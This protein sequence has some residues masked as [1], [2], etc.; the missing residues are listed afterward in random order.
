MSVEGGGHLA[1]GQALV[2]A[3]VDRRRGGAPRP[4][5]REHVRRVDGV[6]VVAVG[7]REVVRVALELRGVVLREDGEVRA[8]RVDG[9]RRRV[10]AWVRV[11]VRVRVRVGNPNPKPKP[12]PNLITRTLALDLTLTRYI[13]LRIK[14]MLEFYQQRIPIYARYA[15]TP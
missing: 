8:V 7:H 2:V 5:A 15:L 3:G 9:E 10:A 13:E 4:R 12:N 11:R 6:G 1:P 14:P